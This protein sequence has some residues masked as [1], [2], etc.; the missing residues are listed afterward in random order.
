[1][2]LRIFTEPQQGASYD[3]L[4]AVARTSEELGFDAFFRSDH[5]LKF[6]DVSGEPGPTDA[7]ITLAG[8]ARDTSTIRLGT[9][10]TPVTFRLPGPLAISVAQVDAMSGGRVELGVGTG[11]FDD[12]HT[13]YGI[14]FPCIG[15]RFD[16]LEE[17]LSVITGLW[18]TP[19]GETFS[20][21]GTHYPVTD[22][23]ALPKPVQSP[24][25]PIVIGGGGAKRTPRLAAKFAERVQPA[26]LVGCRHRSGLRTRPRSL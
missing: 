8:L 21:D 11:W 19:R 24:H 15:E 22:S 1:M 4:L 2:D 5:Y 6:G 7:W 16:M 9:L 14:P 23:P 17:Q 13:A 12:E 3:D 20:F 25:P 18:D 10:V 26:V